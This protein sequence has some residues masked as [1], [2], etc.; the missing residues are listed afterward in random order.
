MQ[1]VAAIGVR[2]MRIK[3]SVVSFAVCVPLKVIPLRLVLTERELVSWEH[4][5]ACSPS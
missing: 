2:R 3:L 5:T 4:W 1:T